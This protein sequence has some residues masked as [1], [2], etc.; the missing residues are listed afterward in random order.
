MS[1]YRDVYLKSPEWESLRLK[2]LEESEYFCEVCRIQSYKMDVHHLNYGNL[3]DVIPKDLM[4]VCR[5]CHDKIHK[6]MKKHPKLKKLGSFLQR[7]IILSRIGVRPRSLKEEK[8]SKRKIFTRMRDMLCY[9][10]VTKRHKMKLHPAVLSHSFI[11]ARKK[12]FIYLKQYIKATGIDPRHRVDRI[13][14]H[15][16]LLYKNP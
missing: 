15:K 11:P 8:F 14:P 9:I 6:L 13:G 1:Y 7:R 4:S 5:G 2:V 12:P 10:R 16:L 3:H